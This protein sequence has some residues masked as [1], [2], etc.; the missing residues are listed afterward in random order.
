MFTNIPD[1]LWYNYKIILLTP[2]THQTLKQGVY[3]SRR[4]HWVT[5]Q[6]RTRTEA[7]ICT[8]SLII[9]QK[10]TGKLLHGLMS[11][12]VCHSIWIVQSEFGVNDTKAQIHPALYKQLVMV[13]WG[14]FSWHTKFLTSHHQFNNIHRQLAAYLQRCVWAVHFCLKP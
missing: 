2:N 3:S 7:T 4:P 8:N 1:I 5:R 13:E 14:I 10:Q 11:L 12:E 6:L 9:G